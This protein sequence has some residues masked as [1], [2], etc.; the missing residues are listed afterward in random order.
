MMK[1]IK[2]YFYWTHERGS[3]HYDVLV[4][5]I[6]LFIFI[7]PHLW[8]YGEKTAMGSEQVPQVMVEGDGGRGLIFTV[9]VAD[10]HQKPDEETLK[11]AL[12]RAIHPLVGDAVLIT[13]FEPVK[14]AQ[15]VTTDYRVWAHR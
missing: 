4:T 5:F 15:G 1:T 6:L 3:L 10:V 14:N 13:Y 2:S 12:H 7:T 8:N 9:H 11:P